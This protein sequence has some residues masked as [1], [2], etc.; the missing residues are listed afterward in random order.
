MKTICLR[1]LASLCLM[2][3]LAIPAAPAGAQAADVKEK[4]RL[5]TYVASWAIPRARWEDFE[6]S[7][8]SGQKTMDQALAGGTILGYGNGTTAVHTAD[9][10][11]HNNWWIANSMAGVL[12]V[13]DDLH[14]AGSS[15]VLLSATKHWDN[16]YVSRFYGWHPGTVKAGYVHGASY[17]LKP[18]APNDAVDMLSKSLFVPFFEKLVTEGSVSAWQVAEETVHTEDPSLFFIFYITPNAEGLDKVNAA[19]RELVGANS[20]AGPAIGSMV[21]YSVHRDSLGTETATLK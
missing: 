5:Y 16:I 7:N 14:K 20:L 21:D 6:K 19:L 3:V 4:P 12:T 8:G 13:L 10:P 15:P 17:K 9:G 2:A 1:A 18:D 11:T